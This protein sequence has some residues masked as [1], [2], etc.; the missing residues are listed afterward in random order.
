M[1]TMQ[2]TCADRSRVSE[3]FRHQR[4]VFN[5]ESCQ[6]VSRIFKKIRDHVHDDFSLYAYETQL[7]R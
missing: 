6:Q 3:E 5:S 1:C 7:S 4:A 2:G